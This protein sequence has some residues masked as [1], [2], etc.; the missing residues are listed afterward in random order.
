ME[1][2]PKVGCQRRVPNDSS[3]RNDGVLDSRREGE[4][5]RTVVA[6]A[7]ELTEDNGLAWE[8]DRCKE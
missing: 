7:G 1:S 4:N 2:G 6:S 3:P 5:G 8:V